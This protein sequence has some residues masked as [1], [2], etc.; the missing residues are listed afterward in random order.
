MSFDV[1]YLDETPGILISD[2]G[3]LPQAGPEID[4][5]GLISLGADIP[6][7][8]PIVR[9]GVLSDAVPVGSTALPRNI[10]RNLGFRQGIDRHGGSRRREAPCRPF[11]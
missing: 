10:S 6:P 2:T 1:L 8:T 9:G 7:S 5:P 11:R 4:T 3:N